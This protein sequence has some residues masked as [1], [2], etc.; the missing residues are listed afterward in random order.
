MKKA[1]LIIN[2]KR[3]RI[4]YR[5]LKNILNIVE[6]QGYHIVVIHQDGNKKSKQKLSKLKNKIKII[7]TSYPKKWHP[8]K[9]NALNYISGSKYCFENLKS[10]VCHYIEDDLILSKDF[11][12]FSE[13]ILKKYKKDN[14]FF[15]F[16]AFSKQIFNKNQINLYSKFIFGIGKGWSINK[17]R[18]IILKKLWNN[19]FL[20][21]D[22]PA[23]DGP[24]EQYV[25][26]NK[27][28]VIMPICSR[29]YEIPSN[30]LNLKIK[31][32]KNYI[33]SLKDSFVEGNYDIKKYKY[34]FF[35]K[36]TWREDC[37]KYKGK[38]FHL[39]FQFLRDC[40]IYNFKT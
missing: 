24:V 35:C 26:R 25:K 16:N 40:Y 7:F 34:S 22:F 30:G 4:F 6:K 39:F 36:Y 21:T 9:K 14:N 15:A 19:K 1:I 8:F 3:E 12:K 38:F 2:Y 23:I 28:F 13:F 31:T 11:F 32:H 10:E 20:N 37:I 5:T 29:V 27:M 17:N 33:K 18:W